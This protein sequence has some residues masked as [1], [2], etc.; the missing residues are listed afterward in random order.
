[1]CAQMVE[2]HAKEAQIHLKNHKDRVASLDDLG[3]RHTR[4]QEALHATNLG[5]KSLEDQAQVKDTKV[6]EIIDGLNARWSWQCIG[7]CLVV[8]AVHRVLASHFLGPFECFICSCGMPC[9][10][11][12]LL[13]IVVTR[14]QTVASE[15]EQVRTENEFMQKSAALMEVQHADVKLKL[16]SAE[17]NEAAIRKVVDEKTT[18]L[19]RQEQVSKLL[20]MEVDEL[21]ARLN[22]ESQGAP[23]QD[24]QAQIAKLNKKVDQLQRQIAD[25]QQQLQTAISQ[26]DMA[27]GHAVDIGRRE[28]ELQAEHNALKHEKEKVA[29]CC[30]H[31][32][33][34]A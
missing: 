23:A 12:S 22:R 15:V 29:A 16:Q 31:G 1:M 10:F 30:C 19:N 3:Q 8:L 17:S 26:R 14:L 24:P 7:S 27:T 5:L 20:Q 34:E 21:R 4:L 32:W 6:H 18:E 28:S 33:N 9:C 25:L 13:Y 11:D 2:L